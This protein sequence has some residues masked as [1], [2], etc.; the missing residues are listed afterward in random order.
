[1]IIEAKFLTSAPTLALTL[2]LPKGWGEVAFLGRSNVGK[3]SLINAL[4]GRKQ[5]AKTSNTPG[6]TR[7]MNF[8]QVETKDRAGSG[9]KTLGQWFWVDLPGYGYAKVSK[10][11]QAEW[12]KH[13]EDYL[14][15][16]GSLS[17]VW[18]LIDSRHGLQPNDAL[19]VEWLA[20][21]AISTRLVLTKTDY[22]KQAQLAEHRAVLQNMQAQL[23]GGVTEDNQPLAFSAKTGQGKPQLWQ[24]M[25]SVYS[26]SQTRPLIRPST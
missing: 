6:K 11:M 25:N 14:Q 21:N 7:L 3:S 16:R 19:M 10:T 24:A 13:L 1:M 22:V 4:L 5:L 2:P 8:Y 12:Q 20:H 26:V 18:L 23:L 15:N 17:Q 9:L